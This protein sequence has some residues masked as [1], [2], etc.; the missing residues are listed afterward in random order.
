[1]CYEAFLGLVKDVVGHGV[2]D[3][4]TQVEHWDVDFLGKILI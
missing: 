1:M 2:P 3:E 4:S